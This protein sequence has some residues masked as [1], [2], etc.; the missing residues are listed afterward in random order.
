MIKP[1]EVKTR[2]YNLKL[3]AHTIWHTINEKRVSIGQ[4]ISQAKKGKNT[5]KRDPSVGE[6]ISEAKKRKCA[7]RRELLGS[8]FTKE[9]RKAMSEC[10][11]GKS[12]TAESNEKRSKTLRE[13]YANGEIS[14]DRKPLS[15]EHKISIGKGLRGIKHTEEAKANMS[16]SQSK[17]YMIK[18]QDGTSI[19][20]VG[21][22]T[23]CINNSI[24]YVTARK[25]LEAKSPIKKY[26]IES[27]SS[28]EQDT[29]SDQSG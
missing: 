17:T 23:F 8:S 25:A 11:I 24:P 7:E 22:K 18:Y 29:N 3:K 10:K 1:E 2:Y 16:K 12:Q 14:Q 9:H 26:S 28:I 5:G 4:K 21:L 27:I 15:I 13:K 20:A 19:V 6:K